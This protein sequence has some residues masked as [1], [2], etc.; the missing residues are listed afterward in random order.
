V[1]PPHVQRLPVGRGPQVKKRL[2]DLPTQPGSPVPNACAH[3]PKVVGVR[4]I[5]G[6]QDVWASG[7]VKTCKMCGQAAIVQWQRCSGGRRL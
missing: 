3:V 4:A 1:Q 2:S 7:T 6:L 5:L